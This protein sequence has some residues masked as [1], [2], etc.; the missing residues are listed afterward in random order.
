MKTGSIHTHVEKVIESIDDARARTRGIEKSGGVVDLDT[1]IIERR[2]FCSHVGYFSIPVMQGICC[3]K[4]LIEGLDIVASSLRNHVLQGGES[5]AISLESQYL[6][7][8][9]WASRHCEV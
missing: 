3:E 4:V 8:S 2:T 6:K 9:T 7:N 5:T 1:S